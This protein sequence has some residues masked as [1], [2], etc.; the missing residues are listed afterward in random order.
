M[1][2]IFCVP[3][4]LLYDLKKYTVIGTLCV[5]SVTMHMSS[6]DPDDSQATHCQRSTE[7]RPQVSLRSGPRFH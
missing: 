1:N 7:I 4:H 6:I 3:F 5:P 2:V